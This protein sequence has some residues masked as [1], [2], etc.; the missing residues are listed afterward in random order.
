METLKKKA[1]ADL[2]NARKSAGGVAELSKSKEYK[3]LQGG[4][5]DLIKEHHDLTSEDLSRGDF[6]WLFRRK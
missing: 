5:M 4:Y 6:I 3:K 1:V 2:A